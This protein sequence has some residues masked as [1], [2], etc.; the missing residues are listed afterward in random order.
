MP[1]IQHQPCGNNSFLLVVELKGRNYEIVHRNPNQ[2]L[3]V[4]S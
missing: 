4:Y 1:G 2:A 3:S